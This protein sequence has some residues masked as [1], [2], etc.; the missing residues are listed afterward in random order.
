MVG[1]RSSILV[2]RGRSRTSIKF[3]WRAV[4]LHIQPTAILLS[5]RVDESVDAHLDPEGRSRGSV[6][7]VGMFL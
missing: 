5:T 1:L 6:N 4:K 2:S 3:L 7:G